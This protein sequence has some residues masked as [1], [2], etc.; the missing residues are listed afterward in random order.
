[1][2]AEKSIGA[3]SFDPIG[4]HVAWSADKLSRHSLNE[5]RQWLNELHQ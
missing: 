4:A 3:P 2:A 1:M 5:L